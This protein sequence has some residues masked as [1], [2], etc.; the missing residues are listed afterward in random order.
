MS[1]YV[2]SPYD[3]LIL[4]IAARSIHRQKGSS[5]TGPDEQCMSFLALQ[6][7]FELPM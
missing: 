6:R 1:I 7:D 5:Q 4:S 3:Q 2:A